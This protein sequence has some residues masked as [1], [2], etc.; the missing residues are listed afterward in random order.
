MPISIFDLPF[1]FQIYYLLFVPGGDGEIEIGVIYQT[2]AHGLRFQMSRFLTGRRSDVS[3]LVDAIKP[4]K[5]EILQQGMQL[6]GNVKML[7]ISFCV[8][9]FV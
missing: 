1:Q 9:I 8:D 4:I 6:F 2:V 5:K 3:T 7:T